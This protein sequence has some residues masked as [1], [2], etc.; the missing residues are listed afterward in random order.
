MR[1]RYYPLSVCW[2]KPVLSK[3]T[4]F[5]ED[6]NIIDYPHESL[7][8]MGVAYCYN[9]KGQVVSF[10]VLRLLVLNDSSEDPYSPRCDTRDIGT[11]QGATP[12]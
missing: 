5:L 3:V 6:P 7:A 9:S 1:F 8:S 10:K 11:D 2:L 12:T 4:G